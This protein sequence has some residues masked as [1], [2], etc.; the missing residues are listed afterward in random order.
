[1]VLIVTF[2]FDF[3]AKNKYN[4]EAGKKCYER[5]QKMTLQEMAKT[6]RED[7]ARLTRQIET[8]RESSKNL[9]G[10]K[11]HTANRNL[12]CLYEMRRD[13]RNIA[14]TLEN[15]YTSKSKNRIYH[16]KTQQFF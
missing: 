4:V 8:L 2:L 12:C 1:M 13:V 9:C 16:K 11:K 10:A 15:Y 3:V 6:Y 14:E 5:T 7:E